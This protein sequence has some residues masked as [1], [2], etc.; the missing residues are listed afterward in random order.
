MEPPLTGPADE[1]ER[2]MAEAEAGSGT[3]TGGFVDDLRRMDET[4]SAALGVPPDSNPTMDGINRKL[5][6]LNERNIAGGLTGLGF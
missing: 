2:R 4:V 5:A 3:S 6:E 1:A